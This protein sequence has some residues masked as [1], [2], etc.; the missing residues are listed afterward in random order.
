MPFPNDY[1]K[2]ACATRGTRRRAQA[3]RSKYP[4]LAMPSASERPQAR[5]GSQEAISRDSKNARVATPRHAR[6]GATG[7][8][9]SGRPIRHSKR[10]SCGT[11]IKHWRILTGKTPGRINT[12]EA[13]FGRMGPLT[14]RSLATGPPFAI[15][16]LYP[17]PGLISW[18]ASHPR[19]VGELWN[20]GKEGAV[21]VAASGPSHAQDAS[22]ACA[23]RRRPA[24]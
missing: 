24:V 5:A 7:R 19:E 17:R 6:P 9:A 8:L 4:K 18:T 10:T 15:S 1:I 3:A 12:G 21:T 13:A 14:F 2:P 16:H 23:P 22:G 20:C 11:E